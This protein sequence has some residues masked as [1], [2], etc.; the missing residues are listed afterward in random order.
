M[1]RASRKRDLGRARWRRMLAG[2]FL[3][4]CGGTVGVPQ[5]GGES[6]FL[7]HC[8]SSS[9]G[10]GLSCI[11]GVCTRG[12]VVGEAECTDLAEAATCTDASIEPGAVAVCDVACSA[13][14]DC[15]A[16]GEEH[17]CDAGFCRAGTSTAGP[18][19]HPLVF[20]CPE[21]DIAT[22]PFDYQRH[23]YNGDLLEIE[24][25]HGGG[26]ADHEYSLCYTHFLESSPV[27]T[28]LILL[29]DANGD[30][31]E[32]YLT[33]TLTFDLSPL[34]AKY[35]A[36]YQTD[37]GLIETNYSLYAFG[38]LSCEDRTTAAHSQMN[39]A[40]L[41]SNTPCATDADCTTGWTS[42]SCAHSCS[43][44]IASTGEADFQESLGF[45]EGAICGDFED[46]CPEDPVPPCV[47]PMEPACVNGRCQ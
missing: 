17:R 3:V 37:G 34:A 1:N 42:V 38:A 36:G 44:P 19:G 24:I 2:L 43:A 6:H 46:V 26:C 11:A 4:S 8:D 45:I 27:Q 35:E 15:S 7:V 41:W 31:C 20:P 33:A 13:D 9:C 22:D 28:E 5:T 12:C 21:G 39:D 16:L 14:A 18:S 29:H 23:R 32:A 40:A 30:T 47:P 25:A 10:D